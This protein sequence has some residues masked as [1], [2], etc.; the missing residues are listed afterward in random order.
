MSVIAYKN[1]II[2]ADNAMTR[3]NSMLVKGCK[4][5]KVRSGPRKGF[6]IGYVGDVGEL[7]RIAK[8]YM[9]GEDG[10]VPCVPDDSDNEIVVMD[11]TGGI[12]EVDHAMIE[13]ELDAEP[14]FA[15]GTGGAYAFGAMEMGASAVEAVRIACKYDRGCQVFGQR[16]PRFAATRRNVKR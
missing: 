10:P 13:T 8:Q 15:W 7:N 12:I 6:V 14:F 3:D 9:T 5:F 16:V 2:A 11:P 1:G 4:L